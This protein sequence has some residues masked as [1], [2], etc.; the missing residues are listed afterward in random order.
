MT[1]P[2]LRIPE[3]ADGEINQYLRL[4]EAIRL[5]E[6]A[7]NDFAVIDLS[8]GNATLTESQSVR[9]F[10][11]FVVGNSVPRVLT[12]RQ[13]KRFF[14]VRNS[15][16]SNLMVKLGSTELGLAA[17]SASIFFSDGNANGLFLV[18]G[19]GGAGLIN[20][21]DNI[22]FSIPNAVVKVAYFSAI[23]AGADLDVA[24]IPKGAGAFMLSVPDNS[25]AGGA[26]RGGRA[27]DLQLARTVA[28]QVASGTCSFVAGSGNTASGAYSVGLGVGNSVSASSGFVCGSANNVSSGGGNAVALGA[29]NTVSANASVALGG[30]NTVSGA[31]SFTAGQ[32]NSVTA[33]RGVAVGRGNVVAGYGAVAAGDNCT[34][35]GDYSFLSGSYSSSA[36]IHGKRAH[37]GGRFSVNGDAQKGGLVLRNSTASSTPAVLNSTGTTGSATNQLVLPNSGA[38]GVRGRVVA[39]QNS[40]GDC[41]YWRFECLVSRGANAAATLLVGSAAVTAISS[42]AGATAWV[43]NVTADTVNGGVAVGV[44]G[45]AGKSIKWV[46]DLESVEVV[47]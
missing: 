2:I 23:D 17:N 4:N 38:F 18:G 3:A 29:N 11:I 16:S 30:G 45:E 41:A 13:A 14:L 46:C 43:V 36:G 19:G 35:S 24:L 9:N 15:G 26:K 7:G 47:G 8:S 5:L 21:S 6:S 22:N 12:V 28:S 10:A 34:A 25:P 37:A 1:S 42:T 27:V 44:I 31:N 32:S 33:D 40:T 39:R 20:F